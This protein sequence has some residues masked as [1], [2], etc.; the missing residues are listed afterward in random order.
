VR[1]K[2]NSVRLDIT[3]ELQRRL[4]E[5]LGPGNVR[6]ITSPPKPSAGG[7]NGGGRGNFRAAR[8]G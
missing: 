3:Q 7:G 8:K 1:L 2:A 5:L 4:D 6:R